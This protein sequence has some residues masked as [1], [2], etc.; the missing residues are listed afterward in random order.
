VTGQAVAKV[1]GVLRR[2]VVGRMIEAVTGA[3]LV[4]LGLRV[5][6]EPR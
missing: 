3:V 2:P 4:G 5:A 6:T 1:G